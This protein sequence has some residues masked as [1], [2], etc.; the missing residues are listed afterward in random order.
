[1]LK[2]TRKGAGVKTHNAHPYQV[3]DISNMTVGENYIF[4]TMW[5]DGSYDTECRELASIDGACGAPNPPPNPTDAFVT[6]HPDGCNHPGSYRYLADGTP[7][8]IYWKNGM[9]HGWDLIS[10][11]LGGTTRAIV[12]EG[13]WLADP[14]LQPRAPVRRR[15]PDIG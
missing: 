2:K 9:F 1:M 8:I 12:P 3:V 6:I 15:L 4:V 5:H 13:H 7:V 14:K 11:F 10:S